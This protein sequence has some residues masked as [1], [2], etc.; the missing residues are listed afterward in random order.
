M[1][2]C[3]PGKAIN[4]SDEFWGISGTIRVSGLPCFAWLLKIF[5]E[6]SQNPNECSH[7]NKLD[8]ARVFTENWCDC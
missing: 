5:N 4:L 8:S 7:N 3:F 1:R 2:T 6:T